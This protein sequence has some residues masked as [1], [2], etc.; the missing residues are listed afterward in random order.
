ME[1]KAR[2]HNAYR[3]LASNKVIVQLEVDY[4][5][6]LDGIRDKDLRVELKQW[7]NR[8]SKDA[9][10][11]L[12]ACLTDIAHAMSPPAD[13]WDVYLL[14]LKRYG[15]HTY[16][17]FEEKAVPL[18]RQSWRESE[19]VGEINVNGRKGI[20]LLLYYGSSLYDSKEFSVLLDGVISE[21][22]EM[23]LELPTPGELR[24]ALDEW[25]KALSEKQDAV[26]SADQ[27]ETLSSI[28]AFSGVKE[29]L[30]MKTV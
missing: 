2:L 27:K 29:D 17:V 22:A 20:Q 18:I 1:L 25:E 9:N 28:T 14:M 24:R 15:K 8:R 10:A 16:G 11:L 21:M 4:Q 30:Q 26:S 12:W 7:R 3:D 6:N 19:V 13:K 23:G 5:P